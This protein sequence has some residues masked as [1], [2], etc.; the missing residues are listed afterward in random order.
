MVL[1][2]HL[3]SNSFSYKK[4]SGY[5]QEFFFENNPFKHTITKA[6]GLRINSLKHNYKLKF[7]KIPFSLLYLF[8]FTSLFFLT[9]QSYSQCPSGTAPTGTDLVV[10]G[11]FSAG[12]TG[13]S[14]TYNY[15][16]TGNCL[17]PESSYAVGTNPNFYH[18]SFVGSD[19][20]TGNGNFMIVNGSGT[21]NTSIWCQTIP[22]SPNS[23]YI[24]STW[25]C[26][27]N[28][29]SP[30]Q[31]QF[32]INGSS[33]GP[34]FSAPSSTNTWANF[35]TTWNSGSNTTATIC[36][37]NQNT[38]LGGNDFGID[39][40]FFQKC[41]APITANAGNNISIC[42]GQSTTLQ[43]SGGTIYSWS[44]GTSL[45]CTNCQNPVATPASTITYTLTVQNSAEC[46]ASNAITVTVNPVP[47]AI[48]SPASQTLCSGNI[49]NIVL[50]SF[51]TGT[52]FAWTAVQSG[53]SGAVNDSG[54]TITQTLTATGTSPGTA[55]YTVTPTANGCS[56]IPI[57]IVITINPLPVV[58]I[59]AMVITPANCGITTCSITG[60]VITSGQAPFTYQ[61]KD[62]LGNTI[63]TSINLIN[64][65]PGKYTLTVTDNNGC[66]I[67]TVPFTIGS[68]A[69]VIAAFI[70][71]FLSGETPLT[72]VFTNN[73]I[74]AT[75]Y[76]WD[77]GTGDTS[78]AINPSYVYNPLG[79]FTVC[80][81]AM[82]ATGCTDTVCSTID[83]YINSA[84]IVP[85]IFTP[86]ADGTNDLFTVKGKGLKTIYAE[87]F[88]RWGQKEYEWHSLGGGWDGRSSSGVAV[89]DGTYYYIIKASGI[90]G[91]KYLEKGA[92]QLLH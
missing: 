45:N 54:S 8:A 3:Y 47:L 44:P 50:S 12:N 19:H 5:G 16:N 10:N 88:N 46:T 43:G 15:C 48:A 73:S 11:D 32:S 89:S 40:I 77:F 74:G 61:W 38:T 18:G 65:V 56:G 26:S 59:S 66:S 35:F 69:A 9:L 39:D 49:T 33:I 53:V 76:L 63:G 85:N 79:I 55:T 30:A 20:T 70:P 81:T 7:F 75:Y 14:S 2:Y 36:I 31:L 72:V 82:S 60:V 23:I 13:F 4:K 37:V 83:V 64:P 41:C 92:F 42:Q 22:V 90:D 58:D 34:V 28:P 87:I 1:L 24:F 67:T 27:V 57:P 52:T 21:P 25:V 6:I 62:S 78:T 84:L 51:T 80:L 29:S 91:K 17:Q 68:T 86:N 71:S